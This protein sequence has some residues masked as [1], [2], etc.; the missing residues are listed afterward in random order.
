M[1]AYSSWLAPFL[2]RAHGMSL[3]EAGFGFGLLTGIGGFVGTMAGGLQARWTGRSGPAG[4]LWLPVA[5]LLIHS[6]L[7][8][9]ALY[10]PDGPATLLMLALPIA[11]GLM[12]TAPAGA[13]VQSR[14]PIRMSALAGALFVIFTHIGAALGLVVA[15]LLSD[16]FL[17][18][19]GNSAE[20]LRLSLIV[21]AFTVSWGAAHW[22]LAIRAMRRN[23]AEPRRVYRKLQFLRR[24]ELE[25]AAG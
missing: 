18:I 20:A 16:F 6:P 13:I 22:L 23:A 15:G 9:A 10:M 7:L 17:R 14:A 8:I 3:I 5:A 19:D 4:T 21:I 24:V 2:M 1:A 11:L 12:W 25:N